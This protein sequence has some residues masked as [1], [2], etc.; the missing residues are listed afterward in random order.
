MKI[1]LLAIAA[2]PDDV[3]LACAGTLIAHSERGFKTG[4]IDLTRGEMGTRGTA[5]ERM[6]E[7]NAA[8]EI[9]GLTIREN[10]GFEDSFFMN[11]REHQLKLVAVIRKYRPDIIITNAL[12]DRHPDHGRG[13]AL[14]EEAVFKSGLR[15]IETTDIEGNEQD[16]W[17]PKKLYFSIQST[18]LTP[19]FYVDISA[20]QDRKIEAVKAYKTQF[21]NAN[22]QEPETYISKPEFMDMIESRAQEYG[23]RIG[24]KY[25]EGFQT[26]QALGVTELYNLI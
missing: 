9:M 15:K 17:R 26:K 1:N 8:A 19:D 18:S 3:E 10:M 4:V 25:A 22:S 24:V 2:H 12:Y 20:H 5:D 7:A 6:K 14:V 11:D 23:H 16:I 13:A 21:F